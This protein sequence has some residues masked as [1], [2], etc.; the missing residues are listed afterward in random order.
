MRDNYDLGDVILMVATDRISAFDVVLPCAIPDKGKV[1]SQLSGFWFQKTATLIPN[2]LVAM[3][4]IEKDLKTL[5]ESLQ[6]SEFQEQILGRSMLVRKAERIPVECVVR[7]YISGSAWEEYRKK[8]TIQGIKF[9]SGIQESQ[10]LDDPIFTPTTKEE[11]GHD[12]P[13]TSE[14]LKNKFGFPLSRDLEEKSISVYI[15][16]RD[17]ALSRGIIIADTKFEFGLI[18]GRLH[19]IDEL[20][21]PDSSRFWF[22]DKYQPGRPQPSLDKQPVRDWLISTGWNQKPPAPM[23]PAEIAHQTS[24]RYRLAFQMLT[25]QDLLQI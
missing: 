2:H 24:E 10:K 16:A 11:E 7:G 19:L 14:Q 21:T 23:L 8:G 6:S 3:L 5:P 25:G 1:L 17:Y 18:D 4:V 22:A 13:L 20:L 9:P 12:L 15:H